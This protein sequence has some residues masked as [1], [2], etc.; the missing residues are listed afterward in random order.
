MHST[1]D[2]IFSF[3]AI[4]DGFECSPLLTTST[5]FQLFPYY[6]ASG[7]ALTDK[8]F[9]KSFL[10]RMHKSIMCG[11]LEVGIQ[12]R[13]KESTSEI[14]IVRQETLSTHNIG[15]SHLLKVLGEQSN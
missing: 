10:V 13:P 3:L 11:L 7:P 9:I 8:V 1:S 6:K 12:Y 4:Y 5:R 15:V 14:S 2:Q